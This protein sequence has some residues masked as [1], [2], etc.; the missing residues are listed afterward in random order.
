[1][2]DANAGLP[3]ASEE[4]ITWLMTEDL[5]TPPDK[6]DGQDGEESGGETINGGSV[7][8]GNGLSRAS[9]SVTEASSGGGSSPRRTTGSTSPGTADVDT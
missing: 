1:M 5:W 8:I 4:L 6:E 9:R 3:P 7:P 2:K